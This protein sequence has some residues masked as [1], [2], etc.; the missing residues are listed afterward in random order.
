M[1]DVRKTQLTITVLEETETALKQAG[2]AVAF[3]IGEVIDRMT[4]NWR[5]VDTLGAAQIILESFIMNTQHLSDTEINEIL[6]F[7]FNVLKECG[8]DFSSE[9]IKRVVAARFDY[10]K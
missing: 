6:Y 4:L 1:S 5:S 9:N 2:N 8:N 7:V 3:T 10:M